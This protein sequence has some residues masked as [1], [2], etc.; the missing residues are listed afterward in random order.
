QAVCM[1]PISAIGGPTLGVDPIAYATAFLSTKIGKPLNAF[2]VR[3]ESKRHGRGKWIEGGVKA[4]DRVAIVDDVITTGK[5]TIKAIRHSRSDDLKVIKVV[6][7]VDRGEG[8]KENIEKEGLEV[9]S[10]FTIKD[11]L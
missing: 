6:V 10:I 11:F 1:L 5:S 7:L 3:K 4:G 8:G 2:V 9:E